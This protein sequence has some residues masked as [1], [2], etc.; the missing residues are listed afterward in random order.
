MTKISRNAPC[1]CG[2]GSKYKKCCLPEEHAAAKQAAREDP[3]P[4]TTP[5]GVFG[6]EEDDLAEL[7]NGVL[8]L[9]NA[10]K[11]EEAEKA[12]AELKRQYPHVVDWMER[13]G[14][15]HEARG[16]HEKA[17]E[18]YQQCLTHIEENPDLFEEA[19]KHW[20]HASI[21]K[22]RAAASE[23]GS[24]DNAEAETKQDQ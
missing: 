8:D 1:P 13:T 22:L 7:S 6:D 11:L 9:I 20:Y 21:E 4:S 18:Y 5:A 10:G 14:M 23:G 2:S 17:I 19:S 12:C 16:E 15:I 24:S 3:I